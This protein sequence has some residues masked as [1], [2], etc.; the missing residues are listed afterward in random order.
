MFF[1]IVAPKIS[2]ISQKVSF[3]FSCEPFKN[4]YLYRTSPVAAS[5]ENVRGVAASEI[6]RNISRKMFIEMC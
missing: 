6:A 3:Q 2:R 5:Q 4:I 1:K